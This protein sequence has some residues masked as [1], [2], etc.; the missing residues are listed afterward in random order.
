MWHE[1]ACVKMKFDE[2]ILTHWNPSGAY[3]RVLTC[4]R[5]S[6]LFKDERD[7]FSISWG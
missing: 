4:R 3:S 6:K 5:L 1:V 7:L 2:S